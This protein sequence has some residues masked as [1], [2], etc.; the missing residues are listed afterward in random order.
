MAGRE[1]EGR[2]CLLLIGEW[3]DNIKIERIRSYL[4][5]WED[6]SLIEK[7]D[8]LS[9]IS[10]EQAK[11]IFGNDSYASKQIEEVPRVNNEIFVAK[12]YYNIGLEWNIQIRKLEAR[13]GIKTEKYIEK[14]S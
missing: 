4:E 12:I 7:I 11:K 13:F 5:A 3:A 9:N 6:L 10:F 14:T 1:P 2:L 8:F